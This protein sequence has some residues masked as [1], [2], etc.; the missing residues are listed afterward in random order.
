MQFDIP[1][2]TT[3]DFMA[4]VIQAHQE[5]IYSIFF[6]LP[7][8]FMNDARVIYNKPSYDELLASLKKVPVKIKKYVTLNGRYNPPINYAGDNVRENARMMLDLHD[9]GL[10]QGI[11]FLDFFYIRRLIA[12][13]P[14]IG[15]LE[16]VPSV[17]CF[18]DTIG[19]F[20]TMRRY[21]ESACGAFRS[22]KVIIDRGLN[23][24]LP[25]L[26]RLCGQLKEFDPQLKIEV[27]VNEG[28]MLYCP[29]KVNH[30]IFISM[31][32]DHNQQQVHRN[33]DCDDYNLNK[34]YGCQNS[35]LKNPATIFRSPFVRPEDIHHLEGK[36]DIL[37]V[38]GKT[39]P[40]NRMKMIFQAYLDRQYNGNLLDLLDAM[41][42]VSKDVFI[43]N[44]KLP[45]DF[46]A[47]VAN[48]GKNCP[49]CRKCEEVFGRHIESFAH[50]P[51]PT[52]L[53]SRAKSQQ[54]LGGRV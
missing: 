32:N 54:P 30:D 7:S 36:A 28:C 35:N 3:D 46:F 47:T 6:T 33:T 50:L 19:K 25:A 1:L 16:L 38:C 52:R 5:K 45:E 27:L 21:L 51:K 43:D 22:K 10:L 53:A 23:R 18:I 41:Q 39:L 14:R 49:A 26:E 40:P 4:S 48:C 15:E 12:I 13:E 24:D 31:S 17:N 11:I 37:K 44:G 20:H 9:Q 34:L 29:F 8:A 42:I 2:K